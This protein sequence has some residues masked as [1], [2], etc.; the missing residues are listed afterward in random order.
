MTVAAVQLDMAWEEPQANSARAA[1]FVAAA[2]ER[3]ATL[4][5]LPEMWPTGFSMAA[6]RLA[7]PP[8]GPSTTFL[9]EQ[10]AAQ[11]AWVGGSL[12]VRLPD[13]DRPVNCFTL[14]APDG[15]V[16][17]YAKI[18]SFSHAGEHDHYAAGREHVTVDVDGCR[19]TLFVCY[20][21]RFADEFWATAP[22]TDC[23][24]VVANWPSVRRRHWR[25]LLRARA[26][27]NQAYV[28]GVNRVGRDPHEAYA[29]DSAVVDPL[30]ELLVEAGEEE[31]VTMAD[32]DPAVVVEVR[33]RYRFLQDRR[34]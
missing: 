19:C 9:V 14:A 18:H 17:R 23:Y 25:T 15:A 21:L 4:V 8:E 34:G 24:L 6:D 31:G 11:G 1:P 12:P 20:D 30:G 33:R 7:E 10:A 13:H 26:I 5:L 29:G 32:V 2:A 22:T 27:E 28:V 16:H 3:G